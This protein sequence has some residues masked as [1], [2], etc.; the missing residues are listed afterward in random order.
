[1]DFEFT[2]DQGLL[3]DSVRRLLAREYTFDRRQ[4]ILAS[5]HGFSGRFW[6]AL[7]RQGIFNIG[8]PETVGGYGG[9]VEVMLV[10][11]ELGRSLV[12]EPFV[13]TVVLGGGLVS[14]RGTVAQRAK[15]LPKIATGDCRI[16]L[17]HQEAGSCYV[18]DRVGTLAVRGR[19]S[20]LL[21]GS[22]AAVLDAPVADVLIVSAR[23]DSAGGLS[24]FLVPPNA[25]GLNSR[26]YRTPDGRSAADL[27]L[28]GV[29]VPTAARLGSAGFALT[30]LEEATDRALA[31]VCAEAV[32]VMEAIIDLARP[33]LRQRVTDMLLMTLQARAMSYLAAYHCRESDRLTRRQGLVA[34][35]AF[36]GKAM[37][38]VGARA[39]ELHGTGAPAARPLEHY[40]SR[41]V[42]INATLGDVDSEP[43]ASPGRRIMLPG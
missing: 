41:L 2:E 43:G 10:M 31:A 5:T 26:R 33:V 7:A 23:D 37:S 11:E 20:Y 29:R 24:L 1:M 21:T 40:L 8:L 13:S 6:R 25:S 17:A 22:K 14:A 18:L 38:L 3:R 36:L 39:M 34:V 30:A 9:P 42:A 32:G 27:T 4:Q 35:K 16:A 15:L 19:G 28:Q 12:L